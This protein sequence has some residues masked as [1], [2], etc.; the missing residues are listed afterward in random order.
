MTSIL[1]F[2]VLLFQDVEVTDAVDWEH[3]YLGQGRH[4]DHF[5]AVAS[6]KGDIKV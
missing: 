2:Y 1:H 3:F 5:L 6:G 4:Q